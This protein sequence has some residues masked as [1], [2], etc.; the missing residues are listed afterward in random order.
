MSPEWLDIVKKVLL[1]SSS[2][3]FCT[4]ISFGVVVGAWWVDR[5]ANRIANHKDA[6]K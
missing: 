2:I 6:T 4:G 1:V 5:L 3:A